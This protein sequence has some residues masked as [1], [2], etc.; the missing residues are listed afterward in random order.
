MRLIDRVPAGLRALLREAPIKRD[1]VC[2][3]ADWFEAQGEGA[4]DG[5]RHAASWAR[6]VGV[7]QH[8]LWAQARVG[9]GPYLMRWIPPGPGVFGLRARRA[10]LSAGFWMGATPIAEGHFQAVTPFAAYPRYGVDCPMVWV[11]RTDVEVFLRRLNAGRH[12]P[13]RLPTHDEWE[14]GCRGPGGAGSPTPA[15]ARRAALPRVA[16]A[17]P[18]RFG[19]YDLPGATLEFCADLF[20]AAPACVARGQDGSLSAQGGVAYG[21]HPVD[22]TVRSARVG[23]RLVLGAVSR[24]APA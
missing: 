20:D 12:H 14:Y 5:V 24:F 22:P 3:L 1:T 2:V 8:G 11:N 9:R 17:A 23:F 21:R 15:G 19:L 6:Q 4:A 13:V 10:R 7:D 16:Q 18:N